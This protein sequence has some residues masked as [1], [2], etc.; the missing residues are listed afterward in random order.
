MFKNCNNYIKK[1][2]TRNKKNKKNN[3]IYSRVYSSNSDSNK[4]V[5][6]Y[7]S[8]IN[9]NKYTF[10]K[11][12]FNSSSGKILLVSDDKNNE[13]ILKLVLKH[14]SWF[15]EVTTL[16]ILNHNHIIKIMDNHSINLTIDDNDL[17]NSGIN[18]N[19]TSNINYIYNVIPLKYYKNGDLYDLLVKNNYFS[20]SVSR[21]F[22]KPILEALVYSY[23]NNITHNDVKLENILINDN[24]D[25]ILCD[26][27]YSKKKI[28]NK[29]SNNMSGTIGYM[30]PEII[31]TKLHDLHK[32]NAWSFGITLF[33]FCFG[34]RPY[35]EPEKRY[36]DE[37]WLGEWLLAIKNKEW[38]K[39]WSS[40]I[41][42]NKKFSNISPELKNLFENIFIYDF[43]DRYGLEDI[44]NHEWMNIENENVKTLTNEE[45]R[46]KILI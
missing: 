27:G 30:S 38:D 6:N 31:S 40:H 44:L 1:L 12:L 15:N 16:K 21:F 26:W 35:T 34:C 10:K 22:L 32:S 36:Q 14:K 18:I 5:N 45:V 39:Y 13:I 24:L 3:I 23:K 19:S 17:I 37:E 9:L 7:V 29:L 2:F 33:S 42:N 25:P 46:S 28:T 8:D 11:L 4:E 41:K 20:E 43:N